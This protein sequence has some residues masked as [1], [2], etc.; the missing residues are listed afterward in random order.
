M[1]TS[2]EWLDEI[3]GADLNDLCAATEEAIT[4]GIGFDWLTPPVR[5]TLEKY[6]RGAVLI[7]ERE[8]M[9]GRLDGTIAAACQLI[10]PASN[11]E[12]GAFNCVLTTFFVAPWAR[13]HGLA[14]DML[15]AFEDRAREAGF[16]QISLDVRETQEPAIAL[17]ERHGYARWGEKKKY[18]RANGKFVGGIFYV[19]DV[20]PA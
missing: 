14:R 7:P 16:M 1:A 9:V 18:A 13:G 20:T 11:N 19:K 17:F 5:E 10:R 12:A 4:A 3:R 2:I 15:G 8:V 6:W